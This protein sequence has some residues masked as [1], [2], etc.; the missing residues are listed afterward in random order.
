MQKEQR[1]TSL[2]LRNLKERFLKQQAVLERRMQEKRA[3][4]N[5][6]DTPARTHARSHARPPEGPRLLGASVSV[7]LCLCLCFE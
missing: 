6:V 1:K 5:Q 3:L 2:A 4:T 7:C